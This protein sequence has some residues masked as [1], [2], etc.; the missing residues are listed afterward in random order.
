MTK[1][2]TSSLEL[3]HVLLHRKNIVR[4][5][6]AAVSDPHCASRMQRYENEANQFGRR[7][8]YPSRCTHEFVRNNT[9]RMISFTIF[10][11]DVGVGPGIDVVDLARRI[12]APHQ[13]SP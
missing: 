7:Y 8:T 5:D 2:L 10:S 3:G 11:E 6:N 4:P 9:L 1:C 12:L 13:E